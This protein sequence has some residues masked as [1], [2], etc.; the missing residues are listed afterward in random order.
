MVQAWGLHG[1]CSSLLLL[2]VKKDYAVEIGWIWRNSTQRK[3]PTTFS[4]Y[5]TWS[6]SK[7]FA[8]I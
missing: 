6:N 1:N 7:S 3:K 2:K 8:D 5:A 4:V